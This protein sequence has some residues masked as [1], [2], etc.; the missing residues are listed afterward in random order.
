MKNYMK[1]HYL[2]FV[3]ILGVLFTTCAEEKIEYGNAFIYMPQ[4]TTTGGVNTLYSVPSGG[5]EMTYNFKAENGKINIQLG[6]MRSGTFAGESFKVD[7][8]TLKNETDKL[9]ESGQIR[10]AVAMPEEI[11]SLPS[12]VTVTNSNETTFY[13]S[14]DSA[15]L[16]ND[17]AYTGQNMVLTV[18][19]A[20]PSKYQ[21]GE[22]NTFANVIVNI[23]ALRDHYFRYKEGFVYRKGNKLYLNGHEYKT[24]SFN[25]PVLSGCGD[26]HELFSDAE[27]DALFAS[28]PD[29]IMVRTWAFPGSKERTDKLIKMAEKNNIKLIL[30]L[31]NGLSYC[32]H[33]DGASNG[34]WSSKTSDW[35]INGYKAEYLAHVKDMVTTY[36]D[37][38]AIGMWEIIHRPSDVSWEILKTF[39]NDVAKEIKTADPN[40]LVATGT[41]AQWAYGGQ[42]NLQAMHDSPYIDVGT[43][44]EA[45][46]D[47]PESWH[48]G[49]LRNAMNALDKVSMVGEIEMEG[50]DNGCMYTIDG[51]VDI[52]KQ[53]YDFYLDNDASVVLVN[54]L[55][56][57]ATRCDVFSLDDPIM[58][59]I[60]NYPTNVANAAY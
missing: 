3:L 41:W 36:K 32:G 53:K 6:V 60:V 46:K 24:A 7:I 8:V 38:P 22:Q 9:I 5:G 20:N 57:N 44:H 51:R 4:A 28:L 49:A 42:D 16:I 54:A 39:L 21:L 10:N 43:L 50:G 52:V 56:K 27:I 29:N 48:Y 33:I 2:F 40:H 15:V 14:V 37:S 30:T 47:R 12:Q 18:G 19:L 23:D 45:D 58:D 55:V 26:G 31:G 13:L 34:E 35:Y 11:Y 1:I 25:A 17:L 59:M